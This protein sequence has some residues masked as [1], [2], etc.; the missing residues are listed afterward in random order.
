MPAAFQQILVPIDLSDPDPASLEK[1]LSL[2]PG[3]DRVHVVNVLAPTELSPM[4]PDPSVKLA[5]Q[6]AELR[7]WLAAQGFPSEVRTHVTVAVVAANAI[8]ELAASTRV[9]LVV[10]ASHGR[11]GL[12]RLLLGS[13][14]EQVVR[15]AP[16]AVLV[17]R[18]TGAG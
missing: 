17:L 14:A 4:A 13:V 15:S 11:T 6:R 7:E 5:T 1:A 9:D 3:P 16:C 12:R 8:C 18:H 10:I 2:A